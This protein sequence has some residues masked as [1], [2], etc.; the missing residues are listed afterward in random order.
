MSLS[1][2][3]QTLSCKG[4]VLDLNFCCIPEKHFSVEAALTS[5]YLLGEGR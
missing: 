3:E 1:Q 2:Q 5:L 4:E